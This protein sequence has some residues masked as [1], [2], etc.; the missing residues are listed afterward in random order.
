MS[1]A[2]HGVKPRYL[3]DTN[4]LIY[5]SKDR[6]DSIVKR[7]DMLDAGEAVVVPRRPG[8][9]RVGQ[10]RPVGVEG[11]LV[12]HVA[13]GAQ[14]LLLRRGRVPQ[15]GQGLVAVGRRDRYPAA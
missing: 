12:G 7:L 9:G 11:G 13:D 2:A 10:H 4:I 1:T 3:L 8:P 5:F 15:Q 6:P 14:H